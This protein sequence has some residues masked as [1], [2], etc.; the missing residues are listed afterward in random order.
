MQAEC[1]KDGERKGSWKEKR[2]GI[3]SQ[4]AKGDGSASSPFL[5]LGTE[6]RGAPRKALAHITHQAGFRLAESATGGAR[7]RPHS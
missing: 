2:R 1:R 3:F 7:L 6:M 4:G 5:S